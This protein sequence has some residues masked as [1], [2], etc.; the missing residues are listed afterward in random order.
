M[1]YP[2]QFLFLIPS[3]LKSLIEEIFEFRPNSGGKRVFVY[4]Q[5]QFGLSSY[6]ICYVEYIKGIVRLVSL[7]G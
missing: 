6:V 3:K 1:L 4:M 5:V 2:I 7:G